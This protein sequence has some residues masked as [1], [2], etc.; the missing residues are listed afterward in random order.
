[1]IQQSKVT[2]LVSVA[3]QA[4]A[5]T[6]LGR[7]CEWSLF[8]PA[9]ASRSESAAQ[10]IALQESTPNVT[11]GNAVSVLLHDK[12]KP[13]GLPFL[14]REKNRAPPP[15]MQ[16]AIVREPLDLHPRNGPGLA[17]FRTLTQFMQVIYLP[18]L[19]IGCRADCTGER[20]TSPFN[21]IERSLSRAVVETKSL[22]ISATTFETALSLYIA[23]DGR[24]H[25]HNPTLS[26]NK[27]VVQICR[28]SL[29]AAADGLADGSGERRTSL[30][31]GIELKIAQ[32]CR[33]VVPKSLP[34]SN[35]VVFLHRAGT[36]AK[37]YPLSKLFS[38]VEPWP[39][40]KEINI[41]LVYS[42]CLKH[43]DEMLLGDPRQSDQRTQSF[44]F[45]ISSFIN[46]STLLLNR[47]LKRQ[48]PCLVF[49]CTSKFERDRLRVR[50]RRR[51]GSTR[52]RGNHMHDHSRFQRDINDVTG[53]RL[54][55]SLPLT[56]VTD[57][58]YRKRFRASYNKGD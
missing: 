27:H 15:V 53:V 11:V 25:K 2:F 10:T 1:M 52:R 24:K 5:A 55:L 17:P 47:A 31:N 23:H 21:G 37:E 43:A 58:Q 28:S 6:Q 3:K 35:S 33:K 49:T 12:G 8:E 34:A 45:P 48:A 51:V 22:P 30:V 44:H 36:L 9:I 54:S 57:A 38:K 42:S 18:L 4:K 39:F 40:E 20:Q 14:S 32:S 46:H 29:S 41:N 7:Q 50:T 13:L 56:K 19:A 16:A 26:A